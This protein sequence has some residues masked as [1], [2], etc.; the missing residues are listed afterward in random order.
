MPPQKKFVRFIK[1][2]SKKQG[3]ISHKKTKKTS[4][5]KTKKTSISQTQPPPTAPSP[6]PVPSVV[7]P[8][9]RIKNRVK[10]LE[11]YI[12]S[13][14]K[15]VTHKLAKHG[16]KILKN[17]THAYMPIDNPIKSW[18]HRQIDEGR[19]YISENAG[20]YIGGAIAKGSSKILPIIAS[21]KKGGKVKKTGAYLLHKGE[22]VLPIKRK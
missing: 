20:E 18:V 8:E 17:L 7:T 13:G 19:D 4:N 9:D 6:D 12:K 14:A 10:N 2:S 21:F 3:K 16:S 11:G 5:K 15:I 22:T 1:K